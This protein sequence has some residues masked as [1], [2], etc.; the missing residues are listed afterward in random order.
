M[1]ISLRFRFL[2]LYRIQC[3]VIVTYAFSVFYSSSRRFVYVA[4]VAAV[5]AEKISPQKTADLIAAHKAILIDA[6]G[7][8]A[9]T[10]TKV[11]APAIL[12][13]SHDF[14]AG[15]IGGWKPTLG[16]AEGKL[17]IIQCDDSC[18]CDKIIGMIKAIGLESICAG[19][20]QDWIDAGLPTRDFQAKPTS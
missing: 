13:S 12:L 2:D 11:A 6:R 19:K 15:L 16:A 18:P 4:A 8:S 10:K 7:P 5:A 17:V 1:I 9:W 14:E 20:P 3:S